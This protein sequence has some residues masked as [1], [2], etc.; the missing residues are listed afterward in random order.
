[1]PVIRVRGFV[2]GLDPENKGLKNFDPDNK[3]LIGLIL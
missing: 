3:G 1:V 2:Q